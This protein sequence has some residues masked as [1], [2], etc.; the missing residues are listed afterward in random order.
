MADNPRESVSNELLFET[1]RSMQET[2]SLHSHYFVEIKD[3]LGLVE[4]QYAS[5]SVRVDRIYERTERI[6]KR[7]G[8]VDG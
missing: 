3:R 7:L 4:Q 6:E 1:L 5:L 2:L 8:L